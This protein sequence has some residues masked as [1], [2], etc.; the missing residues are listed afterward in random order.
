[1]QRLLLVSS[2]LLA[3]SACSDKPAPAPEK[4]AAPAP[5]ATAP[6]A[7]PA[8]ITRDALFGNPE[9]ANVSISPD[10]KYL[11]WVAPLEGVLNVWVAP[12][13]APDQARAIT[14]D[15]ARGIRNYFW[16][17]QPNTLS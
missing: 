4:A 14:K 2:M 16:T 12:V 17:Y 15:T 13:D 5:A 3:L 8:L 1:M 11:S 10:G 9:R 7:P 6:A